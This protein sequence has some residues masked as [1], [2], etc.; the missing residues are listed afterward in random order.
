MFRCVL[1]CSLQASVATA[2]SCVG[3][4]LLVAGGA[5][6]GQGSLPDRNAFMLFYA[7]VGEEAALPPQ[8]VARSTPDG[9]VEP[10]LEKPT[11]GGVVETCRGD[12]AST[13]SGAGDASS[14]AGAAAGA[15]AGAGN[16]SGPDKRL[17]IPT[18]RRTLPGVRQHLELQ[19]DPSYCEFMAL[20]AAHL[21]TAL[22]SSN[23]LPE[24]SAEVW[25]SLEKFLTAAMLHSVLVEQ[26]L[27]R[28]AGTPALAPHLASIVGALAGHQAPAP[29]TAALRTALARFLQ[30]VTA[31]DSRLLQY[32]ILQNNNRYDRR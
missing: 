19:F 18:S 27:P 8:C 22:G 12:V 14:G 10:G 23:T 25:A 11:A 9:N 15:G 26:R 13:D 2:Y 3:G 6:A 5:T 28:P 20:L 30:L 32:C 1:R 7:R 4:V 31:D 16:D 21:A 17:A 29:C 24:A